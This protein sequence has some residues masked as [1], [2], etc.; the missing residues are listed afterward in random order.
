MPEI[1]PYESKTREWRKPGRKIILVLEDKDKE[2]SIQESNKRRKRKS[3]IL[4][5]F[6][7]LALSQMNILSSIILK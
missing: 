4:K 3:E 6:S 5:Y 7:G 2:T 1:K